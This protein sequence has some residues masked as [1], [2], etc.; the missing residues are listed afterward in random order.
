ME[1][2]LYKNKELLKAFTKFTNRHERQELFLFDLLNKNFDKLVKLEEKIHRNFISYCPGDKK[3][4]ER[5]LNMEFK[6]DGI[7]NFNIFKNLK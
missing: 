5:I 7:Y 1:S 3:E 2:D 6:T 4:C